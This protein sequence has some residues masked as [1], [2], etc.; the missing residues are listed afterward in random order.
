MSLKTI[1]GCAALL[2]FAAANAPAADQPGAVAVE[3]GVPQVL[4]WVPPVYPQE[5]AGKKLEGR[6][7]VRFVIDET[8]AVAKARAVHSTNKVFEEATVQSVL[9]WRFE[10]AIEDGRK[11]AKCM[12]VLIPFELAD[13]RREP[14]ATFPPA[15]VIRSLAYSPYIPPAKVSGDD[16]EYPDSLLSRH[17]T[18]VVDV[19]FSFG[20]DG[21]MQALKVL[22]ATHADFIHPALAAAEKWR[23]R[24]AM[25]GDLAVAAPMQSALEFDVLDSKRVDPLAANNVTLVDPPGAVYDQRPRLRVIVDP[26]YPYDLLLAATEGD[27][28]ADFVI[29]ANGRLESIAVR[30]ASEPEVGRALAAALDCWAFNPAQNS[31]QAVAVRA[32]IRWH[33][34]PTSETYQATARLVQRLRN[35]DTADMGARGLDGA[36]TPR[37]QISPVY[38]AARVG[39]KAEGEAQIGFIIDQTGRCRLARIIS[40]SHE[41]FGWAAATAVERWVFDPPHRGGHP[42]DVR[43]N[44]PFHFGAP[45]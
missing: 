7:Q 13:F 44:I 35:N 1:L 14:A 24:P 17:L 27:A 21:Q 42:T 15:K 41:E 8:G 28:A 12:E 22:W 9:Q 2:L 3:L 36:L 37:Y 40:A 39:K 38:P 18:G 34:G 31:G 4:S 32:S 23:F 45:P 26:V 43:V 5:A 6:V 10:P 29:G 20:A 33:F 30:E 25:Q 19:E 11:V 16:P